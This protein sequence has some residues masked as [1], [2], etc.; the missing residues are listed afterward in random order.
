MWVTLQSDGK[1]LLHKGDK[2]PLEPVQLHPKQKTYSNNLWKYC[3]V[4]RHQESTLEAC[5]DF[6]CLFPGIGVILVQDK[7]IQINIS[8]V[9]RERDW[10]GY[11]NDPQHNKEIVLQINLKVEDHIKWL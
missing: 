5:V 11:D 10:P 6:S 9:E 7:E 3:N 2:D 1:L 8:K 4:L